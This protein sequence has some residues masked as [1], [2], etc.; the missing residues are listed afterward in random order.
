MYYKDFLRHR[1]VWLGTAMLWIMLFHL[2]LD[3]GSM[4]FLKEVGYGGV[5]ICFFASGIGC[6]FSLSSDPDIMK[7]MKRR[8]KRLAPT[9]VLFILVWLIFQYVCGRFTFQMALGNLLALQNFTGLGNDFN[10][11]VGATF[12]FYLLTPY[13]KG[14]IDRSSPGVKWLFLLFLLLCSV[15]F[16]NAGTYMITLTRLPVF[17]SGL[18]YGD[19][20]RQ[21]R[22]ITG[23]VIFCLT[24]AFFAGIA[25]LTASYVMFPQYLWPYGLHWYPFLLI[26]PPLCL[27]ISRISMLLEKSKLTKPVL[28]FLSLCGDYSFEFFLV[29]L[30][31]ISFITELMNNFDLSG[32]GNLIW[33]IGGIL[34]FSGCFLLRYVTEQIIHYASSRKSPTK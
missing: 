16:W 20:C 24:A 14:I 19:L 5:D 25:A 1:S 17:Y 33:V 29:H 26:A 3:L 27:A 15:P 6:F 31:L 12:L 13:F 9:Y 2:P 11:Y 34:L 28:S 7:F 18:L 32:F 30:F 10:W 8:L 22:K 23:K 4:N 21:N